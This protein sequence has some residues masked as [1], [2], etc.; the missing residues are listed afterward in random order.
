[1]VQETSCSKHIS[2]VSDEAETTVK[3]WHCSGTGT[4][5][6][7][8]CRQ[9]QL[10]CQP[11]QRGPWCWQPSSQESSSQGGA[12]VGRREPHTAFRPPRALPTWC[13]HTPVHLGAPGPARPPEFYSSSQAKMITTRLL[14]RGWRQLEEHHIWGHMRGR[15]FYFSS[16]MIYH[17]LFESD[18]MSAVLKAVLRKWDLFI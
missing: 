10:S 13:H 2:R 11:W 6:E 12:F 14:P 18:Q 5:H 1:M 9:Q 15:F 3:H 16:K 4:E 7:T 17:Q 8:R